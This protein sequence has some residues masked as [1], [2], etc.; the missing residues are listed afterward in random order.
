MAGEYTRLVIAAQA[1]TDPAHR[2]LAMTEIAAIAPC[3]GNDMTAADAMAAL[4]LDRLYPPEPEQAASR[5]TEADALAQ[6]AALI[7]EHA[8]PY[9]T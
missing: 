7:A 9:F 4:V 3:V 6:A 1:D 2:Q 5:G 8:A